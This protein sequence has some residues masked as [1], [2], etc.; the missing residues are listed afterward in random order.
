M[1]EFQLHLPYKIDS[2]RSNWVDRCLWNI[3]ELLHTLFK[4]SCILVLCKPLMNQCLVRLHDNPHDALL[5]RAV[6]VKKQFEYYLEFQFISQ[7]TNN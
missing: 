7:E 4:F 1:I 2:S 6:L 3:H 5:E